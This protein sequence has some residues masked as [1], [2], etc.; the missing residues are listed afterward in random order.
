MIALDEQ[1]EKNVVQ[2]DEL[3]HGFY[4]FIVDQPALIA[5][6]QTDPGKS[7]PKAFSEIDTL[8]PHSHVNAGRGIFP[9]ANYKIDSRD[10]LSTAQG[11]QQ[12]ILADGNDDPWITGTIGVDRQPAKNAGNYG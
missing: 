12:L 5:I 9:I 2:Y 8:I 7:G 11:V 10:T 1:L 6:L 4:E 3:V